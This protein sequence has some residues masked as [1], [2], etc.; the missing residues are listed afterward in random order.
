MPG[1][2]DP[3]EVAETLLQHFLP[4]KSP[5]PPLLPLIQHKDYTPLTSEEI[6]RALAKSSNT[7]APV[8][9]HIPYSVWKSVHRLM[10]SLLPFLV[11]PLLEHG[12]HP[13]SL[14]K[15]LGIVRDKP[16]KPAYD[17]PCTFRVIVLLR[18]LSKI[19][20]RVATSCVSAQAL[21]C[22]L[23]HTLQC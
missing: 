21:T 23:I 10:S 12:F 20:E 15:A 22:S 19:L 13:H 3:S 16:G 4:Q 5:P 9:D 17:S 2:T 14:K 8:S 1:A 18:T 7:S 6:S 11:D